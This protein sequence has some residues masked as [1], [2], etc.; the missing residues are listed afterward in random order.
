M[1]WGGGAR[2]GCGVPMGGRT[3]LPG[4][5]VSAGA[6]MEVPGEGCGC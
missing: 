5:D 3:G 1:K 2:E 4:E 6:E